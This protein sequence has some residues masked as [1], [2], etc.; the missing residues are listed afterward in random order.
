MSDSNKEQVTNSIRAKSPEPLQATKAG[1]SGKPLYRTTPV[2]RRKRWL[3]TS[4]IVLI[5]LGAI[6][7]IA[8][9]FRFVLPKGYEGLG[10]AL[11]AIT[12][13]GFLVWHLIHLFEEEDKIQ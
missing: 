7:V 8:Y 1:V 2:T 13:G 9:L 4:S 12:C 5:F 3:I 10:A 11:G 6:A